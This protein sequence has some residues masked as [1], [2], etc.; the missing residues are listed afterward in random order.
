MKNSTISTAKQI[1]HRINQ[2]NS[3]IVKFARV[4]SLIRKWAF[5]LTI[6]EGRLESLKAVE[7]VEKPPIQLTIWDIQMSSTESNASF[8]STKIMTEIVQKSSKA[9]W[10]GIIDGGFSDIWEKLKQLESLGLAKSLTGLRYQVEINNLL[11]VVREN[12]GN[13]QVMSKPKTAK[14]TPILRQEFPDYCYECGY[15]VA[16]INGKCVSCI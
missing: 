11:Y 6:L 7:I 5:E 1:Q 3:L 2:L 9:S 10:G 15:N 16:V 14:K 12:D 13:W 4:R 8:D